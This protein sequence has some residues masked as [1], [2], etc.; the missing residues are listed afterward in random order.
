[1]NTL[2]LEFPTPAI[3]RR[4]NSLIR[5]LAAW[6]FGLLAFVAADYGG[7]I[8]NMADVWTDAGEALLVDILDGTTAVP[9]N[10]YGA[11]GTGAGTA[12]KG[13]T[14]LFTEASEA[15]VIT[16]NSQPAANQSRYVYT[17]T[18]DGTKTITNSGVFDAATVGNLWVHFDHAGV[19]VILNDAIE[20]TVT[21]TW[22]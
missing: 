5:D 22:A 4:R 15:R 17:I 21:I 16:T 9:A 11:W 7:R 14:V 6:S 10:W 12:V 3:R 8:L 2:T 19:G 18:A 1:M 20:Y 13:S